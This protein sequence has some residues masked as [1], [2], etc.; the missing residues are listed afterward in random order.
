M[1]FLKIKKG[2]YQ[3]GLYTIEYNRE[4]S[5][6]DDMQWDIFVMGLP[7]SSHSTLRICK[8]MVQAYEEKGGCC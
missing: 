2:L 5:A 1:T 7:L 4:Y 8:S 3:W 6:Q